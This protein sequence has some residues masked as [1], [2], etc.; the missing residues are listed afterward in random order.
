MKTA[1]LLLVIS[2]AVLMLYALWKQK[3]RNICMGAGCLLLLAYALLSV[4]QSRSMLPVIITGMAGISAGTLLNGI[5]RKKVHL[6]H[7]VIRLLLETALVIICQL[8]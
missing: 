5:R 7:H 6:L 4:I 1:A 3:N 8:A 2:Y